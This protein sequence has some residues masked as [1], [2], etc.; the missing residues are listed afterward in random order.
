MI[1][2]V[3]LAMTCYPSQVPGTRR[4]SW[5]INP[6]SRLH[7]H[8]RR[9]PHAFLGCPYP[10]GDVWKTDISG[11]PLDPNSAAYIKATIDAGGGGG[12]SLYV[13]TKEYIN[14]ANDSTPLVTVKPSVGWHTPYT[15]WPWLSSFYISP[16]SDHHAMVLQTDACAYYEAYSTSWDGSELHQ[17]NGG[18]W[19]LNNPFVRPQTGSISTA[20][21]IPIGLLAVRPEELAAGVITH[22]IGLDMTAHSMS[23]TACVSP[24]GVTNCTDSLPYTG[25]SG[26]LPMPYGSHLRLKASFDDSSFP[27]EAK[28]VAEALK[29]FG[30]YCYDTASSNTI[31]A[32]D[33][34]NGSPSWTSADSNALHQ[35]A[36]SNFE[37]VVAP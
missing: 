28:I 36:V 9:R 31:P 21:G 35:L 12:F 13:P 37:V 8:Q 17:Y 7:R 34:A 25:P 14:A 33:D 1:A 2:A 26:D 27:P 19:L 30:G 32:I 16:L 22:A 3:L 15:P 20:S 24:A 11:A 10:S 4:C 6:S 23:Q 29:R 5:H 18:Q